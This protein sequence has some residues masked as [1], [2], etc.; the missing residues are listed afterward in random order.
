MYLLWRLLTVTSPFI[1]ALAHFAFGLSCAVCLESG[2]V[3]GGVVV[4]VDIM[5]S[6]VGKGGTG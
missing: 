1:L 3:K 2:T 5:V 4:D 6:E